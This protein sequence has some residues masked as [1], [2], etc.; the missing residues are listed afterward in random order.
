MKSEIMLWVG[1]KLRRGK[2]IF[3]GGVGGGLNSSAHECFFFISPPPHPLDKNSS[4]PTDRPSYTS[5]NVKSMEN[6]YSWKR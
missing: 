2:S 1:S 6:G 3:K 5:N 4:T